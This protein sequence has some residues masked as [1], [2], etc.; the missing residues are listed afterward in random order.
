MKRTFFM[1]AILQIALICTTALHGQVTIGSEIPPVSGALLDLKEDKT[2][3]NNATATK[4]LMMPRVKLTEREN[5]FPMFED[6]ND[7]KDISG[8]KKDLE[9]K[10]HIGLIVHNTNE[11]VLEGKGLY[12]WTNDGWIKLGDQSPGGLYISEDKLYFSSG[13][14]GRALKE[15]IINVG[16]SKD[17]STP[18]PVIATVGDF[19][20]NKPDIN[21]PNTAVDGKVN[22]IVLPKEIDLAVIRDN[23]FYETTD[24]NGTMKMITFEYTPCLGSAL[25]E[26]IVVQSNK[27]LTVDDKLFPEEI[28]ITST[29]AVNLKI[30]SNCEWKIKN[31]FPDDLSNAIELPGGN[32]E[33]GVTKGEE[34]TGN[35]N[36]AEENL[37]FNAV[38]GTTRSRNSYM[39]L[40]DANP[41]N[42]RSRFSDALISVTQCESDHDLKLKQYR[43]IWQHM[44]A[45]NPDELEP[46]SVGNEEL[47]KNKVMW[48]YYFDKE[49][50]DYPGQSIYFS[51]MYG[52]QRWMVTNLSTKEYAP[53]TNGAGINPEANLIQSTTNRSKTVWAY[54]FDNDESKF[55]RNE[56]YGL[57]YSWSAATAA[58]I[59]LSSSS[60]AYQYYPG[61]DQGGLNS[62]GTMPD[63][64]NHKVV[65]G[66]CPE[67]WHL[68]SQYEMHKL[69]TTMKN[70]PK[71][72]S[73]SEI[74]FGTYDWDLS[75]IVKDACAKTD[76]TAFRGRSFNMLDGGFNMLQ[77]GRYNDSGNYVFTNKT[78]YLWSGSMKTWEQICYMIARERSGMTT[79]YTFFE[80]INATSMMS[81]RCVQDNESTVLDPYP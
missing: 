74:T 30:K 56:R 45:A 12:V 42:G 34:C 52:D 17:P 51:A 47:N 13:H 80:D 5:L 65:Q 53:R 39:I 48:H 75:T 38:L 36:H 70:D 3:P 73:N 31:K 26:L 67:G 62:D 43:I 55:K 35:G 69:A 11:C 41:E 22:L 57:L 9:D 66:I 27:A 46:N 37:S 7:Y 19:E 4:G 60:S 18:K 10:K 15:Q 78:G 44:Y 23:P 20:N 81:V 68:P 63:S 50:E 54:P 64:Y 28:K 16:W 72:Y 59:P 77:T 71:R 58:T 6:D 33:I 14:D 79:G 25:K 76:N 32:T 1:L 49:N 40:S 24:E 61:T 21:A 29:Q 2:L 8:T